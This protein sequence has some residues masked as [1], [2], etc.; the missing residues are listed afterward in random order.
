MTF[1]KASNI[2]MTAFH[3][4]YVTAS[5]AEIKKALE[6]NYMLLYDDKTNIEFDVELEDGTVFTI[7][8]WKE[9]CCPGDE[10][11]VQYHIGT[12]TLED[13]FKVVDALKA[14]GLNAYVEQP[15]YC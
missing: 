13:T 9:W 3:F 1:K 15:K 2:N 10:T 11:I 12:H 8:D 14:V 5:A 6:L 7:Y 4:G